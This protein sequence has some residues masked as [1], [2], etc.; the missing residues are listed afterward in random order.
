M[1]WRAGFRFSRSRRKITSISLLSRSDF[2][3][4]V[5]TSEKYFTAVDIRVIKRKLAVHVS[6]DKLQ[7]GSDNTCILV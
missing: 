5:S 2:L 7:V 3:Y 4:N 6:V 1:I